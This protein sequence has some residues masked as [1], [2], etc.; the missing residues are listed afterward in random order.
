MSILLAETEIDAVNAMLDLIGERNVTTITAT[1][2]PDVVAAKNHLDN[3]TKRVCAEGWW[4]NTR[5]KQTLSVTAGEYLIPE[6][7]VKVDLTDRFTNQQWAERDSKLFNLETGLDSGFTEDLTVDYIEILE[8]ETLPRLARIYI[9]AAAAVLFSGSRV[10]SKI[11]LDEIKENAGIA[12]ADLEAEN[13]RSG[14]YNMQRQP[15]INRVMAEHR[16]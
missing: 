8:Y 3:M 11:E 15:D 16:R 12:R 6:H 4:F 1:G 7:W 14:D 9:S 2:R 5:K 13:L 10:G